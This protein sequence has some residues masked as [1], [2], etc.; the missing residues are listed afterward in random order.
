MSA[1]QTIPA[2]ASAVEPS[3]YLTDGR[4]LFRVVTPFVEAHPDEAALENCLTLE[5]RF[6]ASDEL[7]DM[8]LRPV[9]PREEAE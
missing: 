8:P 6:Y 9:R 2:R 4:R 3:P 5:V 1:V 7:A